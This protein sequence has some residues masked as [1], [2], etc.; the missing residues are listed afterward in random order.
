[1]FQTKVVA[2]KITT[3]CFFSTWHYVGDW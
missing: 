1:M 3:I 2:I